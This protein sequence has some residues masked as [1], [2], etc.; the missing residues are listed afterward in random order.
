MSLPE[1]ST[2]ESSP[3]SNLSL[4]ATQYSV[5]GTA[6]R[7]LSPIKPP[8][9]RHSPKFPFRMRSRATVMSLSEEEFLG[10][11]I[12]STIG[13]IQCGFI[14]QF[15]A[16]ACH[17]TGS[18][19]KFRQPASVLLEIQRSAFCSIGIRLPFGASF[20]NLCLYFIYSAI[21]AQAGRYSVNS[22]HNF[23]PLHEP[24]QY[25]QLESRV[26]CRSAAFCISSVSNLHSPS[27]S[28]RFLGCGSS[29]YKRAG[30][31]STISSCS[32]ERVFHES[33]GTKN[34]RLQPEHSAS[35]GV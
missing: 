24:G 17:L 8:Q 25:C 13:D 35:T 27:L 10:R 28:T 16:F 33:L 32:P 26:Y 12:D 31:T 3:R 20:Y 34:F 21:S 6:S 9:A 29:L 22:A 19:A 14:D 5:Q 4:Q 11:A 18:H 2:S 1:T 30:Q 7:R 23:W 15:A